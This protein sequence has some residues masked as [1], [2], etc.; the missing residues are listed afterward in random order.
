[1]FLVLGRPS[2]RFV[3]RLGG[4][5]RG[6]G[7]SRARLYGRLSG[8][9]PSGIL[10]DARQE[11]YSTQLESEAAAAAGV[12]RLAERCDFSSISQL[13]TAPATATAPGVSLAGAVEALASVKYFQQQQHAAARARDGAE[14]QTAAPAE[15]ALFRPNCLVL[16]PPKLGWCHLNG[17]L[18][19]MSATEQT[20]TR[21]APAW[22]SLH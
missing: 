12:P 10:R 14:P 5:G 17:L 7:K 20:A 8:G 11:S 4:A 21:P 1:M 19:R 16:Q 22:G 9:R 13:S 2:F 3:S 18:R 15:V 6:R